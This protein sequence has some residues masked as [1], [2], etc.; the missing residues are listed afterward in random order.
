[1]LSIGAIQWRSRPQDRGGSGR[2]R[3]ADDTATS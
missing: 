2:L 3:A 1:M